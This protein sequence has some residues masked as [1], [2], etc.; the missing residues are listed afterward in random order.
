MRYAVLGA[1]AMGSIIGAVLARGGQDVVLVDPYREHM[2]KI[3]EHGLT[4]TLGNETETV[5]LNACTNPD[6]AGPVDVIILLVK[7]MH[8][9]QALQGARALFGSNTYICTLQNGLGTTDVL[10]SFLPKERVL[11]GMLKIAG[12]LKEPGAVAGKIGGEVAV[13]LGSLVNESA[14]VVRQIAGHLSGGGLVAKY[15]TNIQQA[16]WEK[17]TVNACFNAACGVLRLRAGEYFAHPEGRRLGEDIV[18]EAV[19]VALA[20]GVTLDFAAIMDDI[21]TILKDT[22]DHYPS[23]AQDMRNKR[24]TEVD[25]LNGAIARYGK[26]MGIATPANEYVARFVKIIEDNYHL[27]F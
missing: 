9:E 19:A 25:A 4:V 21:R 5:R 20:K 12:S 14:A 27:Q 3:K 8:S 15:T 24:K 22:G 1:G 11:L 17:V 23:M 10:E 13:A 18:R 2:E 16:I 7:R 26:E 6:E